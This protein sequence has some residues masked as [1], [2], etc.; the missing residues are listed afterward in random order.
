MF[1][2]TLKKKKN[3]LS[4]GKVIVGTTTY[5]NYVRAII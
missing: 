2:K 1:K 3:P 5:E 4:N